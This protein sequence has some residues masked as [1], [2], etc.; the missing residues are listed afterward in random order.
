[1][2]APSES[3]NS[4]IKALS[5]GSLSIALYFLLF[6]YEKEI[7]ELSAKGHWYFVFPIVIAFTF[8][9]VHGNF[10]GEFWRSLGIRAKR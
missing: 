6:F 3:S 9:V 7:L 1:M 5:W 10:T 4:L 2:A 8:S